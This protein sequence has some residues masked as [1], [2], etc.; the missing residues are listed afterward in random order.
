MGENVRSPSGAP[1]SLSKE[2]NVKVQDTVFTA[3]SSG[4]WNVSFFSIGL[5]LSLNL[6][7]KEYS[8]YNLTVRS[9]IL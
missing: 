8:M 7:G 9:F 5:Q 4:N 3:G 1:V 6:V 2:A